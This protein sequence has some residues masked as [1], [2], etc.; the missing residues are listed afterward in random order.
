[1]KTDEDRKRESKAILDRI[2]VE[3]M[4]RGDSLTDRLIRHF[5]VGEANAVLLC[6][7]KCGELLRAEPTGRE[8]I[9]RAIDHGDDVRTGR[10]SH[11]DQLRSQLA[12]DAAVAEDYD[13]RR[14]FPS[15]ALWGDRGRHARSAVGMQ[16]LHYGMAIEIEGVFELDENG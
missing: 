14:R 3:S 15:V 10:A 1:M 2:E 8:H 12:S 4:M 16:Q 7:R 13:I 6:A 9:S 5:I 11:A